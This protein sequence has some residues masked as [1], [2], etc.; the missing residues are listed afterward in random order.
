M[1]DV[2]VL[3]QSR[4]ATGMPGDDLKAYHDTMRQGRVLRDVLTLQAALCRG[5][6]H[7]FAGWWRRGGELQQEAIH[8]L[9]LIGCPVR[10]PTS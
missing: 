1:T 3:E 9:S 2:Q 6:H 8:E 5:G 4:T 10:Y 7:S